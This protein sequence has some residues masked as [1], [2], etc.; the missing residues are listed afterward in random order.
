MD[1]SFVK[2]AINVGTNAEGD[3]ANITIFGENTNPYIAMGQAALSQGYDQDGI[4]LGLDSG[5]AK[6][7]MKGA[8]GAFK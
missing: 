7:S 8:N 1:K 5:I 3:A 4:F 6:L 2:S